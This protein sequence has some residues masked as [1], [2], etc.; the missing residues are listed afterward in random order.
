MDPRK[1]GGLGPE[2]FGS[3]KELIQARLL[4]GEYPPNYQPKRATK[5]MQP[6]PQLESQI[7]SLVEFLNN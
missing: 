2:I 6:L 5:L 4:K 7:D 1:V 3:S